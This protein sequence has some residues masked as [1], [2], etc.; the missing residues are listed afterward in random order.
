MEPEF[1]WQPQAGPQT[2]LVDCPAPLIFMGGARGGGKTDGVL[3]KWAIQEKRWGPKVNSIMF[4]QTNV[5]AGAGIERAQAISLH[6]GGEGVVPPA[7]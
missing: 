6:V 4:R 7:H 2:S 5:S 3:G 1:V